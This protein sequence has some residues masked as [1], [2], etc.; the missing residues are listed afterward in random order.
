[1]GGKKG[2]KRKN[3]E[4]SSFIYT[5]CHK[6]IIPFALLTTLHRILGQM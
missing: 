4:C 1:M 6:H 3:G 5:L 2:E